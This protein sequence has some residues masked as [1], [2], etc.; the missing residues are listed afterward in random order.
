MKVLMLNGS[1]H[2]QGCTYTALREIAN[3]LEGAGIETEILYLGTEPIRDCVAC[4][5]C[6]TKEGPC[7]FDDDIVN[8]IIEKSREADGFVFGS[9]V[10]YS[11]PSGRILSI[12]DRVFFTTNGEFAH[13]PAAAIVSARRAGTSSALDV[14]QKYINYSQMPLVPTTYWPMVHGHQPS[15][16]L[17]DEEGLQTMRNLAE[18]MI[19]MLKCIKAGK[20]AGI[21]PPRI[22]ALIRTN[23][24]R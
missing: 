20:A 7:V 14:L 17:Q 3:V 2:P 5:V 13:K 22:G 11:H 16:V 6:R 23:F 8:R 15:D 19:W 24:M 21:E 9:P 4:K 18:N 10:Y 1:P 12:L